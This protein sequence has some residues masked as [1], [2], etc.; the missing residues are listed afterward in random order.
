MMETSSVS[1]TTSQGFA[2]PV[3]EQLWPRALTF[4]PCPNSV[5]CI[6]VDS[7]KVTSMA[8]WRINVVTGTE[9]P[10]YRQIIDQIRLAV[11][12]GDLSPGEALPTVR[13][14]AEQ[15]LVNANTVAKSYRELVREGVLESR[16]S[17]GCF[18][19]P[20]RQIYTKA[21]RMR[22]LRKAADAYVSEAISLDFTADEIHA[23]VT[24][25]LDSHGWV[26]EST[27]T[28]P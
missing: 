21:E 11:A 15:L 7:T 26:S 16:Q 18:V 14:L 13:G 1:P 23:I 12:T 24:K 17:R 4:R 9:T 22:R 8:R 27:E 28:A 20:K 5:S 10:I 2:A 25:C 6:N 19:A 3:D